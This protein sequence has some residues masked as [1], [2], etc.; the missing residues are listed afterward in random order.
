MCRGASLNKQKEILEFKSRE[1]DNLRRT[2][3]KKD[4]LRF[5]TEHIENGNKANISY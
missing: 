5:Q 3:D 1:L 4:K 2:M